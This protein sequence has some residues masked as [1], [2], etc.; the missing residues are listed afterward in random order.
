MGDPSTYDVSTTPLGRVGQPGDVVGAVAFLLSDNSS[1]I[2]GQ[3]LLV[4]GGRI[5]H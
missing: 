4:N 5:C 2:S 1:F 3:V